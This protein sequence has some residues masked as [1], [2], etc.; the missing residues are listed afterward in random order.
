MIELALVL[1]HR[2][3][4][5]GALGAVLLGIT[6]AT[7][8]EAQ[9]AT[10]PARDTL[11]ATIEFA[12]PTTATEAPTEAPAV[13]PQVVIT[14]AT[15]IA[16][17]NE[18]LGPDYATW[19]KTATRA[20]AAIQAARASN[21]ALEQLR[22]EIAQWRTAF[23][24]A[25][26]ANESR[27]KTLKNQIST[28]GPAPDEGQEEAPV[29]SELRVNL[30]QQLAN[31]RAPGLKAEESYTRA[32]GLVGEIDAI[33]RVRQ[34]DALLELGPSP[35]NPAHWSDALG[36][37][38]TFFWAIP[39]EISLALD[40]PIQSGET[41]QNLPQILIYCLIAF[42]LLLRGQ[43][44]FGR[45]LGRL[46]TQP[47]GAL[48]WC[49]IQVLS[50][51]QYASPVVAIYALSQAAYA[52]GLVG[53][54]GD[55]A[56]GALVWGV[57]LMALGFWLGHKNF[58]KPG[59][60]AP[61]LELSDAHRRKGRFAALAL[62]VVMAAKYGLDVVL[63][64][65]PFDAAT[66]AVLHFPIIVVAALMLARLAQL[67]RAHWKR[68]ATQDEPEVRHGFRDQIIRGLGV[69]LLAT[70]VFAP[71]L[72]AIGYQ[73]AAIG[74]IFPMVTSVGLLALL[75]FSSQ[76]IEET[77]ALL[78]GQGE[79]EERNAL[80][81]VLISF[82]VVVASLPFFGLIWGVKPHDLRELWDL[83]LAGFT[84]GET[85]ISP[86]D[87]L[88]FAVVFAIGYTIT[89]MAQSAL[90]NSVLPKTR[91][92]VGG[93]NAI[94]SGLGY[95]GVFLAAIVAITLAGIDLSSLAIVAGALSVGIGFGLQNIV[96]NFVSG[97]ILLVERPISE[98]DW[99]EVGGQMGYVR[100]ISVRSTRIE[101]F[102]RTDVIVPNG[103]LVSGVVT[104]WTRGNTVGRLI[105][106]VGVAYGTDT[107]QVEQILLEIAAEQP[108]V[109]ANPAPS[110][111]FRGLGAD[112]LDFELRVIL[113]DVNWK[114][115]VQSDILHAIVARFTEAGIEIPFAQRDLW[116][117]N[118]E[119]LAPK[120]APKTSDQ[121]APE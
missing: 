13:S 8:L 106:P 57:G 51:A 73:K 46:L 28:L 71:L 56:L 70:A 102:D 107:K 22:S 63:A 40:N 67:L 109:L 84:L 65:G 25:Q 78:T 17:A 113:R 96:S 24:K 16:P 89:R 68:D 61:L 58:P 87:F 44:W 95:I 12:T 3:R 26:T 5:I 112:S 42:V 110:A 118:P 34:T 37:L 52:T 79:T 50:V 104:N 75:S 90:R 41:K 33:F 86:T 2:V 32:D 54:K 21:T 91:I 83:F 7:S 59:Y 53:I 64:S 117:R 93:Q 1:A 80:W 14:P 36:V 10:D 92:D 105:V 77:F 100:D 39:R 11:P 97:I 88:T 47:V 27:I 29:I 18:P 99:I 85:K 60:R 35:V 103:D 115:T 55:A 66:S 114:L 38:Q 15:G 43:R 81:P 94:V 119:A 101:T 20:E 82:G 120:V 4:F 116:L 62:G 121:K 19:E 30:N 98:G 23:Q 74:L 48:R 31:L 76:L 72:A 49:R 111:P 69:A 108:M 6:W 45:A 9:T